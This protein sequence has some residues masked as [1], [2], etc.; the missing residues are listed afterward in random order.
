MET[1]DV[2]FYYIE[3]EP[4]RPHYLGMTTIVL[5]TDA[6][7]SHLK[8]TLEGELYLSLESSDL[9]YK[10]VA[11]KLV[12]CR[13]SLLCLATNRD[14]RCVLSDHRLDH[15]KHVWK[16]SPASYLVRF[17]HLCNQLIGEFLNV[18]TVREHFLVGKCEHS[19]YLSFNTDDLQ[20]VEAQVQPT[21]RRAPKE[22]LVVELH[23]PWLRRVCLVLRTGQR[24]LL[25]EVKCMGE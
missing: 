24:E 6:V 20:R 11:M 12:P 3:D 8:A 4:Y 7:P 15:G 18:C 19:L 22:H 10:D 1:T 9:E 13:G 21:C 14:V 2:R 5:E 17:K 25:R 23:Y 16:A